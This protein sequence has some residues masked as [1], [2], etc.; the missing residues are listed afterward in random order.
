M[1]VIGGDRF[2]SRCPKHDNDCRQ[3]DDCDIANGKLPNPGDGIP[4]PCATVPCP[5]DFDQDGRVT[6]ADL[7]NLLGAWGTAGADLNA[8]GF[9]NGADLAILL[10]E[11]G[12]CS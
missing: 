3:P 6:A 4:I 11:W 9:T 1:G 8:D 7:S 2:E 12:D 5:G 10:S